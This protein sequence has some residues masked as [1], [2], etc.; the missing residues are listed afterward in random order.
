MKSL[1][2][3]LKRWFPSALVMLSLAGCD[4]EVTP[5][6]MQQT[7][8]T[9]ATCG[10]Q[11]YDK[12][13][14]DASQP[15]EAK[16]VTNLF[17]ISASNTALIWKDAEKTMVRVV[18]WTSFTGYANDGS[19][20]YTFTRDVFVTAAPQVQALCKTVE[21]TGN[22]RNN[23]INQ[24]LGL[25][26]EAT[27]VRKIAELWVKPG[28]LYRPCPDSQVD[29]TTCG[30][31]FPSDATSAHKTWLNN[32]WGSSY[33]PWQATHYPFTGLGYTYD[34]CSGGTSHV[35]ASEYVVKTGAIAQFIGYT[36]VEDYCAH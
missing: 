1:P 31:T 5:A 32:Y 17:P 21:L 28:D 33:S 25:P 34:W 29:D 2:S 23:R 9:P 30:L 35:G 20:N 36:A 10:Q 26:A 18:V 7:P 19:G 11:E 12:A 3:S 6:E 15:T 24:Y 16:I 13:N 22:E 8:E 4:P 14:L 27:N